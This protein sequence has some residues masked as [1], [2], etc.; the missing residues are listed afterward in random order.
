MY[1]LSVVADLKAAKA[2]QQEME[3]LSQEYQARIVELE[4]EAANSQEK[5]DGLLLEAAQISDVRIAELSEQLQHATSLKNEAV[6]ELEQE[7]EQASAVEEYNERLMVQESEAS[8]RV[9]EL[10]EVRRHFF[11][12]G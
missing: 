1:M 2:A 4:I 5:H 9:K 11:D 12:P 3:A 7:R 6:A 8:S 10:E